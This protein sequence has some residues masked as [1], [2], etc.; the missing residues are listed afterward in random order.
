MG[1]IMR[2]IPFAQLVKWA[3][4]E[5]KNHGSVFGIKKE[6][7]F[8]PSSHNVEIFGKKTSVPIGPSAGPHTQLAQNIFSCFLAGGRFM[9]LKT[10]QTM[11]GEELRKA[12]SRPSINAACE[13]YNVEWSTELTVPQAL[14][15]YIKAYFLCNIFAVEFNIGEADAVFTMSAGYSLDG[16]KSE[17]IDLFIEG[18]KNA[19]NTQIW[20][21][22]YEQTKSAI[23]TFANFTT[24]NLDSIPPEISD[25]IILSTFYNCPSDE[26]E[27]IASYFINEKKLHTYIKCNPTLLGF[28]A[29]R[30]ILDKA[31]Y[32][33][34]S[35]ND[36][37][38]KNDLQFNDAL[39]MLRR[40]KTDAA[41]AHKGFGVKLTNTL[42]VEIKNNELPGKTMYLSGRALFPLSICAAKKICEAFHGELPIS[43]SGG[44]DFFNIK[45]ILETGVCPVT[46]VTNIL[47]PD[48]VAKF[49]RLAHLCEEVSPNKKNVNIKALNVLCEKAACPVDMKNDTDTSRR[50]S[51]GD[52]CKICADVC[53][54][55]ANISVL[56]S[57][58]IHIDSMCNECGNCAVFC[59]YDGRPFKDKLTIFACEEDFNESE[60]SGFLKT[61]ENYKVRLEN[62]SVVKYRLGGKNIPKELAALLETIISKYGYLFPE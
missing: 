30:A 39:K 31:G 23:S 36:H 9:E 25:R 33:H 41:K 4:S 59:P 7:F 46:M 45:E 38:F 48:G 60:N 34:I 20:Q 16:I 61:G 6:N 54:N 49:N 15:E 52:L 19:Q 12:L 40:L 55:R 3:Q 11:D 10:V 22:C 44:V 14:E 8:Y 29:T 27:K 42:P 1:D 47:K 28:E 56:N 43:Y 17:K 57:R 62:K 37:F 13:G 50:L 35:F 24:E 2:P 53:P 21:K 26:T 5:Y 32:S 18:M 58:I 51:C